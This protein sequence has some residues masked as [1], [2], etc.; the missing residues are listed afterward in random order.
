MFFYKLCKDY[1]YKDVKYAEGTNWEAIVCPNDKGHQRSGNRIGQ[2]R[3]EIRDKKLSDF[4]TTFLSEWIVT[5]AVADILKQNGVS[6]YKL[7]PVE[8]C[9]MELPCKLWE[10]IVTGVGGDAHSN[11]GIYLK[12]QCK[13]CKHKRYSAFENGIIVDEENWDGSDIFTVTGY[14]RYLLVTEKVKS[15]IESNRFTGVLFTA[16]HELK[17]PEGVVKP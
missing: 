16:S 7:K 5:D 2:L 1:S 8:V 15:I 14:P 4:L 17:W 6:G 10:F 12:H 11:S 3:I 9:N 13:Y